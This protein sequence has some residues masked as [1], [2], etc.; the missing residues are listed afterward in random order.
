M[1]ADRDGV[2]VHIRIP[3]GQEPTE[4][5]VDESQFAR[6]YRYAAVRTDSLQ[7]DARI[8]CSNRFESHSDVVSHRNPVW[9]GIR[10][11]QASRTKLHRGPS[12]KV[13]KDTSHFTRAKLS[14]TFT[15]GEHIQISASLN[16]Q[17]DGFDITHADNAHSGS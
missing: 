1:A 4:R 15:H 14:C 9:R 2:L 5:A 12:V 6:Q 8:S 3:G 16:G 7:G 10:T 11:R 17:A 13:P